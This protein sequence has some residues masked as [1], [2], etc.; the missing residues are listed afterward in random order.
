MNE[1]KRKREREGE[2]ERERR[3][4]SGISKI[5]LFPFLPLKMIALPTDYDYQKALSKCFKLHVCS[6][7]LVRLIK[8]LLANATTIKL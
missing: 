3:K 2:R 6:F 7:I 8:C 1:R 5:K 4:S